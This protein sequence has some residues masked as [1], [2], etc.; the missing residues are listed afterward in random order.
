MVFLKVLGIIGLVYVTYG[1]TLFTMQRSML[2]PRRY[3][4]PPMKDVRVENMKKVWLITSKGKVEAWYIPAKNTVEGVKRPAVIFS[5]GNGELI[6]YC[7]EEFLPYNVLGVDLML[8]E[9][10]GYGRSKGRPSQRAIR[11]VMVKAY[12]WLKDREDIDSNKI[13]AH[14]RSVGGGA[15]CELAKE[16]EIGALILQS[17]FTSTKQFA[18]HYLL[19][20]FLVLDK[21][22][23]KK[24]LKSYNG[25]VLL[26]HGEHD[27]IIP[28]KNSVEL[29]KVA[30]NA[31]FITYNCRHNDC[32][33][34]V[35][36]YW[37]DI[38]KF[39][40]VNGIIDL[41]SDG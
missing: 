27:N 35:Y 15:S 38:Q 36:Q 34:D 28:Y 37:K 40:E 4:Q 21:F 11:E 12:D 7:I 9:Y 20:P 22:N 31:T 33:P 10:P 30:K 13:I 16:R 23:N 32:P 14:G 17:T 3:A 18:K 24:V 41:K 5:H 1:V 25:P 19:P 8:V 6:D 29:S 39:L 2:F 26:I